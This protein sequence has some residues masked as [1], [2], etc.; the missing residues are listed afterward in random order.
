MHSPRGL[1][2]GLPPPCWYNR[3]ELLWYLL[4]PGGEL[5]YSPTSQLEHEHELSGQ[6]PIPI[7]KPEYRQGTLLFHYRSPWKHTFLFS[8][9]LSKAAKCALFSTP[10]NCLAQGSRW[11]QSTLLE[12]WLS[13]APPDYNNW[14][15]FS[16]QAINPRALNKQQT[17]T[18]PVFCEKGPF[19]Q[20]IAL[21]SGTD[22]RF[23]TI[24]RLRRHSKGTKAGKHHPHTPLWPHYSWIRLPREDHIH[25]P[26]TQIFATHTQGKSPYLTWRPAMITNVTSED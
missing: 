11:T 18:I 24:K 2:A 26:G 4:S 12:G 20:P 10:S 25:S 7:L 1:L 14:K 19:T 17:E 23:P 8:C 21:A 9:C 6:S 16:W 5:Q 15:D 13:R 3:H 22:L